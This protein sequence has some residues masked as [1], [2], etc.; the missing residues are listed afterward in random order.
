MKIAYPVILKKDGKFFFVSIPDCQISTQGD[1]IVHAI[2][3]ARDAISLW[4]ID[5]LED[6]LDLPTPSPLTNIETS[7]E[8]IITLVDV[9]I[10]AYK[11]QHENRTVRRNISLPSWLNE[12]ADKAGLNVSALVQ[13]ALK[14]ELQITDR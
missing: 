10:A 14:Q 4:S 6:N 11:R 2:E 8:D 1:D 9:D 3:M 5:R 13:S 7:S 12:A